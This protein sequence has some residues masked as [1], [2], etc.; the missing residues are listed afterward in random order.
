MLKP[1][2]AGHCINAD[3]AGSLIEDKV[4]KSGHGLAE[5]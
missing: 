1:A 4:P 3:F 5:S 2:S